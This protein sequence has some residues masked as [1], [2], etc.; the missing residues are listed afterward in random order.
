MP[1]SKDKPSQNGGIRRKTRRLRPTKSAL[2]RDKRL[3]ASSKIPEATIRK[4]IRCYAEQ[5]TA[6]QTMAETGLSH[7]TV[8]R[9]FGLIR[10]RL[11]HVRM[12]TSFRLF[13]ERRFGKSPTMDPTQKDERLVQ[14]VL[15]TDKETGR[16]LSPEALDIIRSENL[17]RAS[18]IFTDRETDKLI[19]LVIRGTGPLN[20]PPWP[21]KSGPYM[22]ES[23][24]IRFRKI[25]IMVRRDVAEGTINARLMLY[26]LEKGLAETIRDSMKRSRSMPDDP[27]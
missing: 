23:E 19:H 13:H 2:Y 24:R 21:F 16:K 27:D 14:T 1:T 6:K 9:L 5:K 3:L 25:L 20:K 18:G 12:Y 26:A 11:Y 17:Y 10:K 22:A 4:L 7:V 15:G 8:Y